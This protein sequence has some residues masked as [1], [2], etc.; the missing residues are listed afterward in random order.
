MTFQN[1]RNHYEA[2]MTLA[3][4]YLGTPGETRSHAETAAESDRCGDD[5]TP[6]SLVGSAVSFVENSRIQTLEVRH[7][8]HL[9]RVHAAQDEVHALRSVHN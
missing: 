1:V 5:Y 4:A 3:Q 7:E 6:A 2:N 8:L 9:R